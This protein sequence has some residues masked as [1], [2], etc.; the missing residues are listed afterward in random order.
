[1]GRD[2]DLVQAVTTPNASLF[3]GGLFGGTGTVATVLVS[4]MLYAAL[5]IAGILGG[6]GHGP[7]AEQLKDS[8]NALNRMVSSW[9]IDPLNI[10]QRRIDVWDL[11]AGTYIYTIGPS[12]DFDTT[13]PNAIDQANI[14]IN[15]TSPVYRQPLGILITQQW[16]RIRYQEIGG[17]TIPCE[18]YMD[19]GN[20]LRTLYLSYPPDAAYQLELYTWQALGQA[21]ETSDELAMPDG[22]EEA[23]VYNLAKRIASLWRTK[24]TDEALVI[25]RESLARVQAH[26]AVTPVMQCDTGVMGRRGR[27]WDYRTGEWL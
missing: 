17:G 3:N 23:I 22:Y 19:G 15:T 9:N 24:L 14:I 5:R 20:P 8:L 18:L 7:G 10:Y 12:G 2:E 13:R 4:D 11:V 21:A 26:N 1:M 6:A 16:S 27:Y 25:A